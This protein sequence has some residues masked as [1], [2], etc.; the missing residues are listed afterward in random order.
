MTYCAS[1]QTP[2]TWN[3]KCI[4]CLHQQGQVDCN[5]HYISSYVLLAL[6]ALHHVEHHTFSLLCHTL[7]YGIL[8]ALSILVTL[9]HHTFCQLQCTYVLPF[10]ITGYIIFFLPIILLYTQKRVLYVWSTTG[11]TLCNQKKNVLYSLSLGCLRTWIT[12]SAADQLEGSNRF[13]VATVSSLQTS[14]YSCLLIL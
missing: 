8:Y 11:P 14:D 10:N 3:F 13:G 7:V 2:K 1:T 5:K 12:V 6:Q 9:R 4:V